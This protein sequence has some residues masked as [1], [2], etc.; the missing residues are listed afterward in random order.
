MEIQ[1]EIET[2]KP[3]YVKHLKL[4]YSGKSE[5]YPGA[6]FDLILKKKLIVQELTINKASLNL[7]LLVDLD[8]ET[9]KYANCNDKY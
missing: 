3:I 9:L 1:G 7:D 2:P 4:S 8:V 6:I 5:F